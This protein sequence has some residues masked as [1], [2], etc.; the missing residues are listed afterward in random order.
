M[1]GLLNFRTFR[2]GEPGTEEAQAIRRRVFIEEQS[3]PEEEEWDELD[4]VALHCLGLRAGVPV[5]TGRMVLVDG[6]GKIGRMAVLAEARGIGLGGE[7]L[8]ALMDAAVAGGAAKLYLSAQT[9]AIGFYQ[10]YGFRAEGPEY[11]DAGIPHR[12]MHLAL[13][14]GPA[15]ED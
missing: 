13:G 15:R 11:L 4:A 7:V 8:E 10:R 12:D 9:Y 1:S 3:V 2:W 5:A 14:E 6:T